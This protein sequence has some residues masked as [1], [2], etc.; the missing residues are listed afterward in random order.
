[1]DLSKLSDADLEAVSKGDMSKVSDDGLAALA[2]GEGP[3]QPKESK[4]LEAALQGFGQGAGFGYLPEMQAGAGKAMEWI[5]N[6]AGANIPEE[7]YEEKLKAFRGRDKSLQQDSTGAYAFGNIGGAIAVPIPGLGAAKAATTAGK[8]GMAALKG[9]AQGAA[10]AGLQ[11]VSEGTPSITEDAMANLKERG[12]N[13]LSG[14]TIGGA[15][16]AA[17]QAAGDALPALSQKLKTYLAGKQMGLTGQTKKAEKLI[18]NKRIEGIADFMDQEGMLGIGKN[19]EDV[20]AKTKEIT[21]TTG[22]Q[23]G[24]IYKTLNNK[25]IKEG[26]DPNNPNQV[27][28][29]NMIL[30]EASINPKSIADDIVAK[31]KSE[32]DSGKMDD[33]TF[34]AISKEAERLSKRQ[35]TIEDLFEHRKDLDGRLSKIY[36]KPFVDMS[37]KETALLSMRS[38]LKDRL[39]KHIGAIDTMYPKS[40]ELPKLKELNDQFSKAADIKNVAEKYVIKG[41]TKNML[42]LPE[43][44]AAAGAGGGAYA[45][46]DDPVGSLAKAAAVG[47]GLR[48]GRTYGPTTM[49]QASKGAAYAGKAAAK[50]P[51]LATKGLISPWINMKND[52]EQK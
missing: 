47:A 41:Q 3:V 42:G 30:G 34:N 10:L 14:A 13:A 46:G 25:I 29:L 27:Q 4:P 37:E 48:L 39:D 35:G 43:W 44:V 9:G 28:G 18:K 50:S 36:E 7:S 21:D 8:V 22:K 23:I 20:L 40:K 1:M 31:A 17:G 5:A 38:S 15:F 12:K 2:G 49:Y 32:F 24:S 16:G 33:A 51:S 19:T 26:I 45:S 11:N 6:K 52:E